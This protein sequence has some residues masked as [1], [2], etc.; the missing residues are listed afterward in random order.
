MSL[1][2]AETCILYPE[3]TT[4]I[5]SRLSCLSGLWSQQHIMPVKM[6]SKLSTDAVLCRAQSAVI[7]ALLHDVLDDTPATA[8]QVEEQFGSEVASMVGKVSQLSSMNQLLRRRRRQLVG[9]P[10][11]PGTCWSVNLRQSPV[12]YHNLAHNQTCKAGN[13]SQKISA[14]SAC[15]VP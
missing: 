15:V 10:C 2:N 8:Q 6:S 4:H 1:T 9:F 3:I 11:W 14:M 7:A 13:R 12:S 5:T